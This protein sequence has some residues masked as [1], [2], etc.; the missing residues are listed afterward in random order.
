M[1]LIL[2]GEVKSEGEMSMVSSEMRQ[3]EWWRRPRNQPDGML[4]VTTPEEERIFYILI[5]Q[6]FIEG[7]VCAKYCEYKVNKRHGSCSC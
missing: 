7:L 4:T 5:E 3:T 2:G 1:D 6:M